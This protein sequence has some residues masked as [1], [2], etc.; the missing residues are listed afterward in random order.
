MGDDRRLVVVGPANPLH[1]LPRAAAARDELCKAERKVTQ[2]RSNLPQRPVSEVQPIKY[3]DERRNKRYDEAGMFPRSGL[4]RYD[5]PPGFNPPRRGL[6]DRTAPP[7]RDPRVDRKAAGG[8]D[9]KPGIDTF[10]LKLCTKELNPNNAVHEVKK[11]SGPLFQLGNMN[12]YPSA[13]LDQVDG[14]QQLRDR[15]AMERDIAS[16]GMRGPPKPYKWTV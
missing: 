1:A 13:P 11:L 16:L 12:K 8:A 4:D 9:A 5:K 10:T 14:F 3:F 6:R 2:V 7:V 15:G